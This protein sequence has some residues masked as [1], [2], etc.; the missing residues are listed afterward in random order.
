MVTIGIGDLQIV[1]YYHR[2]MRIGNILSHVCLS[3]VIGD[4]CERV[5]VDFNF[6]EQL[7]H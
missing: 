2:R 5:V 4:R 6:T 7:L 1:F 3:F